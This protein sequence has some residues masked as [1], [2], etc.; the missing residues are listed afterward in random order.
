M[1]ARAARRAVG[2]V[3]IVGLA[4]LV[5]WIGPGANRKTL[6]PGAVLTSGTAFSLSGTV[7][8]L[9]PGVSSTLVL[10][11]SNPYSVSITLRSVTVSVPS[12]P[13]GCPLSNLTLN[14]TA[15]SEGSVTVT[16]LSVIVP[17]NGTA[18]VSFPILVAR[19]A[20]NGCQTLTFPFNYTGSA[21]YTATT[22]TALLTS[23]N[24]SNFGQSVTLTATVTPN[25]TPDPG[26][27]TPA[28]TVTF[29]ECT[30]PSCTTWVALSAAKTLSSGHSTFSIAS[31]AIGSHVL[32][33]TYSPTD[34]TNFSAGSSTTVAQVV[35]PTTACIV[36]TIN[37]GLTV[38]S[39]QSIC[40]NSPGRVNGGVTVQTGGALSLNGATINGGVT[41]TGA[42]ALRFCGSA[43]VNGGV[44]ASGTTGFIM[45]GDKGD[46]SP[47][48]CAGNT[49]NGGVSLTNGLGGFEFAANSV[50]GSVTLSGNT[51]AGPTIEDTVPEVEGNS[52]TGGLFCAT[53]NSPALTNGGQP[54]AVSGSKSGQCSAAG[55]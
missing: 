48:G 11:A 42:T 15:F 3:V 50:S 46:D 26:A 28:G 19:T 2:L 37:A 39:G 41:A 7:S 47:P 1:P 29:Y 51:G 44:T 27:P 20:P 13:A 43:M 18:S 49:I 10:T 16:D 38:N 53:S 25:V 17:H 30:N 31:L 33:A 24:P 55:F 40:I 12:V 9:T 34:P 32:F 21:T 6:L 54:N 8:N 35:N 36:T 5:M 45:I 14:S 23:P 52:I 4:L 22:S